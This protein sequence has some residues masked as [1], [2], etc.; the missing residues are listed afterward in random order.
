MVKNPYQVKKIGKLIVVYSFKSLIENKY[1]FLI[2]KCNQLIGRTNLIA[3]I[4]SLININ[5]V[6]I[7]YQVN[8]LYIDKVLM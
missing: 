1:H 8:E 7:S 3:I 5:I 6:I 4:N 2:L